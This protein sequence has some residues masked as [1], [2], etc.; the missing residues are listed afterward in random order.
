VENDPTSDLGL[1]DEWLRDGGLEVEVVRPHAGDPLPADLD[2]YVGLVV[3]GGGQ[4][5]YPGPDGTPGEPWFDALESL[6]R[7]AVRG[8]TATLGICLGAQLLATSH[9]G[10]VAPATAG[11]EIGTGLVAKR[12]AAETDPLF[13]P[14]PMLPD[15]IQWH[16][17]EVA[18]LP[19]GAVLL[20]TS[21]NYAV[22][23]FRIGSAAWGVQFHPECDLATLGSWVA[24]EDGAL[25]DLGRSG[26]EILESAEALQDDLFEVWHPFA[27]RFAAFARGELAPPPDAPVAGRRLPLLGE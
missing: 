18:E 10:T 15:V 19:L 1:F 2:G 8:R 13:G 9:S 27:I 17:D 14:I 11:P 20:A 24:E 3:L 4:H 7:K 16:Y 22:Q 5:V 6:L 23:A 21:T 26:E 25:A 12:D